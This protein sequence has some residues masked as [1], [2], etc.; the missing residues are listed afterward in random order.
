[1]RFF[2]ALSIF[3]TFVS[4]GERY[5]DNQVSFDGVRFRSSLKTLPKD[6]LAFLVV[7][8]DA[9]KS[10]K[11]ALEAGR[12]EATKY[13]IEKLSTSDIDWDISPDAN[14]LTLNNGNL[15]LSGRCAR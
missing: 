13:C 9:E 5:Q 10:I 14:D 4:C 6:K 7:V 15:E 12:Y 1:M 8:R 2:I 11:G 3:I